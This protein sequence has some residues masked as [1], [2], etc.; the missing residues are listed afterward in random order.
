[1]AQ[2]APTPTPI[3]VPQLP[4]AAAKPTPQAQTTPTPAPP[5]RQ[6]PTPAPKPSPTPADTISDDDD[7]VRVTSNLV[8]VPASVV[9]AGGQPV[10]GLKREDFRLEEEGRAQEVAA[11]G[12]AEQVPLDI[13]LL[14]DV[15][16][17]AKEEFAF[18]Q[19]AAARFLKQVLKPIDR[20][21]IF[22]IANK[23]QLQQPLAS[24]DVATTK[25]KAI[26]PIN[27]K[28]ATAFYDSIRAAAK[29][30]AA[31]APERNRRVI[32]VISDGEDNYS[33]Q[34]RDAASEEA[35][36]IVGGGTLSERAKRGQQ[37]LHQKAVQSVLRDVQRADAVFYSINPT[38]PSLRL[39]DIS[40][41][42]QNGMQ[43]MAE[44]TGGNA[45]VPAKLQDL[46][47]IFNQIAAELRA[48]YLLQYQSNAEAPSGKFLNI[49][50]T[51]P[52]RAGLTIRARQGYYKK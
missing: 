36:V 25:I 15:S 5:Q 46:E 29:Y 30:L 16:S 32:L 51:T 42:A 35:T 38:G 10:L 37:Q 6:E 14:F 26:P 11:V 3:A 44:T 18:Q 7:V 47:A 24:S 13:A 20:A 31:N 21:A 33:D 1:M 2:S 22:T 19:E 45:F 43:Q 4:P 49:K 23:T 50:V 8:V 27:E 41:R 34:I 17:S 40:T 12:D 28:T 52:A 39:N 48:Q 9:D